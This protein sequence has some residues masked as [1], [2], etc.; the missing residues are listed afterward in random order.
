MRG[1]TSARV[2]NAVF[3]VEMAFVAHH[4]QTTRLEIPIE[5]SARFCFA[6]N[7][8]SPRRPETD[9]CHRRSVRTALDV[10]AVRSDAITAIAVE[11]QAR[12]AESN[13]AKL[14]DWRTHGAYRLG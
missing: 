5:H 7:G 9:K 13:V 10:I 12:R 3:E 6:T 11:V 14:L 1:P 4:E 8:H 2:W